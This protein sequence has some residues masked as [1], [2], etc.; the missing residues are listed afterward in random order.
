MSAKFLVLCLSAAFLLL[1]NVV[2]SFRHARLFP[3]DMVPRRS[4]L[5]LA[6][7]VAQLVNFVIP[8]RLGDI[9]RI[10]VLASRYRIASAYVVATVAVERISDIIFVAVAGAITIIVVAYNVLRSWGSASVLV[11]L[12]TLLV[13]AALGTAYS[14]RMRRAIWLISGVFNERIQLWCADFTW[15]IAT[16]IKSRVLFSL[17]FVLDTILMWGFYL[18]SYALFAHAMKLSTVAVSFAMLDLPQRPVIFQIFGSG[19]GQSGF[20]LLAVVSGSI[21]LVLLYGLLNV[22]HPLVRMIQQLR[23]TSSILAEQSPVFPR[24]SYQSLKDYEVFLD[25]TFSGAQNIVTKMGT[26]GLGDAVVRRILPGGS[27]AVAAVVEER[28]QLLIRKCADGSAGRKL[29]EQAK[30]LRDYAMLLPL[31]PVQDERQIKDLFVY[32]MPYRPSAQ[33][34]FNIIHSQPLEQSQVV[35]AEV[36][37]RMALFH[38]KTTKG[39]ASIELVTTYLND[40]VATNARAI[41]DFARSL[42]PDGHYSVNGHEFSLSEWDCLIDPGWLGQQVKNRQTASIHGDLT[43]ENII[44]DPAFSGGWYLIDPNAGNIFDSPLIDW[45]KLMQSLNLGY[46]I[47]NRGYNAVVDGQNIRLSFSRSAL[48]ARLHTYYYTLLKERFGAASVREIAFHEMVNY[49]RLTPYKIR[50]TPQKAATFLAC[51]SILLR[52]YT[53]LEQTHNI[54]RPDHAPLYASNSESNL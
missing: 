47:F 5:L 17:G 46:E 16:L 3:T 21:A 39:E 14:P 6:L 50:N 18:T 23:K 45:A 54:I 15:N 36:V 41:V 22:N 43:I 2:R 12:A 7:S 38:Q 10:I 8:L 33:D 4:D 51:T 28:G 29:A 37:D 48:Y 52:Q 9:L 19:I 1:G 24:A 11:L 40:K 49:L 31:T 13:V 30:W 34:F 27:D 20:I 32:D 53:T 25:A 42:F 35:L 44:V 26:L